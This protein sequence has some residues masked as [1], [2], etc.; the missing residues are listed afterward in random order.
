MKWLDIKPVVL[1]LALLQTSLALALDVAGLKIGDTVEKFQM[2]DSPA[3][4]FLTI[5]HDLEGKIVRIFYLQEGLPND[6]V[7]QK[8]LVNRICDKYGQ[9]TACQIARSEIED[10]EKK[11]LRFFQLYENDLETQELRARIRR[12]KA[13]SLSPDLSVEIDLMESSYAEQLKIQRA[14]T[15]D[16]INF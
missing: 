7:T 1:V 4:K 5:T 8:K 14:N 15:S 6:P 13:F 3:K 12:T 2:L 11:F 10:K 16:L 9:V